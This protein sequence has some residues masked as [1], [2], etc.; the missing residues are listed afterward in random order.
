MSWRRRSLVYVA[1]ALAAIG[2][3]WI[4]AHK[5]PT[6]REFAVAA[7]NEAP[8]QRTTAST[9]QTAESN[10]QISVK[11]RTRESA[12]QEWLSRVERDKNSDWKTPIVFYGKVVDEN[13]SPVPD[14]K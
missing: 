11:G 4:I 10:R 7:T 3:G 13:S 14:A 8:T 12:V 9:S 6:K 1:V 2:F 5:V